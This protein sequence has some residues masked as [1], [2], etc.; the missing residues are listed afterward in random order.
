LLPWAVL[1]GMA[2]SWAKELDV[3]A[4]AV[5]GSG[6]IESTS[7]RS[8]AETISSFDSSVSGSMGSSSGSGGS[9]GGGGAGG[10]GGGGGGGGQ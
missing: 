10:G 1:L 7:N 2:K 4:P 3:L 6:I 9:G 8:F 5:G